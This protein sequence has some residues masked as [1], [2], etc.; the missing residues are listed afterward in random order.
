[1]RTRLLGWGGVAVL[2][3]F[4]SAVSA[5]EAGKRQR[6]KER[7]RPTNRNVDELVN[8]WLSPWVVGD[9]A[10]TIKAIRSQIGRTKDAQLT[11]IDES[12]QNRGAPTIAGILMESHLRLM[13]AGVRDSLSGASVKE[14]VLLIQEIDRQLDKRFEKLRAIELMQDPLP[15]PEDFLAYRNILWEAHVN[16]NQLQEAVELARFGTM[17]AATATRLNAK[18]PEADRQVLAT[19][20]SNHTKTA[21]ELRQELLERGVEL[22]VARIS[23][24]IGQLQQ[25]STNLRS[26][27]FAAYAVGADGASLENWI[28]ENAQQAK[29]ELFKDPN[30]PENL[31]K[32]LQEGRQ[33][34]GE[35]VR[36]AELL[37]EGLHWWRRGR[38]GAGPEG[39]GLLKSVA[40][41]D[42]PAARLPLFMPEEAPVPTDP[43]VTHPSVWN[44]RFDRRHHYVWAW[45]DRAFF[46]AESSTSAVALSNPR[47]ISTQVVRA[48]KGMVDFTAR[49][50]SADLFW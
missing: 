45:Q 24:A 42:N 32:S 25:R 3:L 21:Q 46:V 40:A 26:R 9:H 30:L 23:F 47:S 19:D 1:M 37:F 11:E 29:R 48:K 14:R 15:D 13:R 20:F 12:L 5:D 43:F 7:D 2:C 31:Q 28:T 6:K 16:N 44:P 38:Y 18:V 22:R 17:V 36:K 34:A 50:G 35:M 49:F 4:L 41:L 39:E 27:F 8:K 33:V 10:T